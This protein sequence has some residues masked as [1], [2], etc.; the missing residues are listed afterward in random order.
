MAFRFRKQ[1]KILPGVKLNI[2][3]SGVSTTVGRR[4]LSVTSGKQGT[5]LNTGLSGTGIS[6]R[7]KISGTSQNKDQSAEQYQSSRI[8]NNSIAAVGKALYFI[9]AVVL[10]LI[11]GI[12]NST[13]FA[14][15]TI[16]WICVILLVALIVVRYRS[17]AHKAKPFILTAE[18]FCNE[19]R[20]N[21]ALGM[22]Q[23]AYAIYP[24][25]LIRQDI[26]E[27]NQFIEENNLNNE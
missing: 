17:N 19:Y 16:T 14:A 9:V 25:D 1:V 12:A 21:E 8:L 10:L 27:L 3:K 13:D 26:E 7:T 24:N 23:N 15:E 22:L 18:H 4:G 5:H 11:I 20:Y 2:S 6:F